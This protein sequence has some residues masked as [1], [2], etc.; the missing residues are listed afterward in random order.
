MTTNNADVVALSRSNGK[1][2]WVT[3][4]T[5]FQDEARR[6]PVLWSG[7]VLAGNRLLITGSL[8]DLLAVSPYTGEVM[9]K[10]NLRDPVRLSPVIANRTIY[11]LTDSGRLIALR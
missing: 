6:K 4:L 1:I 3:P 11:V 10:V 7:P 8:G 2:K 5:Q 9:G